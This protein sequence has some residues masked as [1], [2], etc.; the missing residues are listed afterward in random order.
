MPLRVKDWDKHFE[1]AQSRKH[2]DRKHSWVAVPNKHDGETYALLWQQENAAEIFAA[3]ILILQVASKSHPRGTLVRAD[4]SPLDAGALALKTRAPKHIFDRAMPFLINLGWLESYGDDA[5]TVVPQ[6]DGSGTAVGTTLHNITEQDIKTP[7]YPPQ[8]AGAPDKPDAPTE[9]KSPKKPKK[10]GKYDYPP[11][12]EE[13]W[14]VYPSRAPYDNPKPRALKA[15]RARIR[16]GET[17]DLLIRAARGYA[18]DVEP[19]TRDDP[20]Q[21]RFIKQAATFLS[22]DLFEERAKYAANGA[23]EKP[24][25]EMTDEERWAVKQAQFRKAKGLSD[26][27]PGSARVAVPEHPVRQKGAGNRRGLSHVG[28]LVRNLPGVQGGG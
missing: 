6:W 15:W 27:Q 21:R 13:F 19:K 24:W 28:G 26:E 18:K 1:I 11:E 25:D 9:E 2:P 8:G 20:E 7:P 17:A 4:G 22:P 10:R 5:T 16:E 14:K 3:W 23:V 12:F